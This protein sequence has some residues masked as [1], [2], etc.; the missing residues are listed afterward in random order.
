MNRRFAEALGR[1]RAVIFDMD[2]TLLDSERLSQKAW[3]AGAR[4][5]GLDVPKEFFLK[6][7]GHRTA[8]CA[9]ILEECHGSEIPRDAISAASARHYAELVARGV[10]VMPGARECIEIFSGAGLKI[11]LATST[12]RVNA[13]KKL[14]AARLR[15]FFAAETCG[16]E[17]AVGKPD[18]EIY[19]TTA[20]R[21]GVA[22]AECLAIE[23]SPTGWESAFR[24]GCAAVLVPD[25]VAPTKFSLEHAIA[26]FPSLTALAAEISA[27]SPALSQTKNPAKNAGT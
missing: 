17:V 9:R 18:P 21:L 2:G 14:R 5:F 8:D 7:I 13:E 19:A 3:A 11:G 20:A 23:D 27:M 10:P 22:A 15:D 4:E 26:V 25:L 16:D 6:M 1:V 24:A 12:R